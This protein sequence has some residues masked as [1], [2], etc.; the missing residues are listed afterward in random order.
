MENFSAKD[1]K[2][3]G[4][5]CMEKFGDSDA[6]KRSEEPINFVSASSLKIINI[7]FHKKRRKKAYKVTQRSPNYETN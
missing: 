6:N 7:Y 5:R 2:E 1:G 4:E 3:K